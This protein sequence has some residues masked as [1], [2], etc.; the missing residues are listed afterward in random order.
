MLDAFL[1]WLRGGRETL[2]AWNGSGFDFPVL[3]E[4]IAAVRPGRL[5]EWRGTRRFDPLRWAR[6]EG[7]A[8]LPGRTNRL[9]A[10]AGAIGFEGDDAGL[11]GAETARRYRAWLDGGAEPDW[12]RHRTYCENDV[13][14]LEAVFDALA[15]TARVARTTDA[16]DT[17][18]G[19]LSE[20]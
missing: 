7:N 1:D 18:Q 15:D 9:E 4:R 19:S 13:R 16:P 14:M 11:T 8:V 10:V 20:F 5:A 6:E 2:V 12:A 3:E 17:R